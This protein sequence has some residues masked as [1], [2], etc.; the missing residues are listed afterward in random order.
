MMHTDRLGNRFMPGVLSGGRGDSVPV[1]HSP[2][3]YVIPS[4][5]VTLVA[6]ARISGIIPSVVVTLM[7]DRREDRVFDCGDYRLRV[8]E[9]WS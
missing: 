8:T 1:I 7:P 2:G 4:R 5:A 3:E 6:A 9:Q